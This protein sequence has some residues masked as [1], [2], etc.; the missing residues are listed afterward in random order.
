MNFGKAITLSFVLFALFIGV[1]VGVCMD[2]DISLVSPDYYQREIQH[3]DKMAVLGQTLQLRSRP[4]FWFEND[5]I[6]VVWSRLPE[7][8]N[9]RLRFYRPS[10]QRLDRE[11]LLAHMQTDTLTT[12]VTGLQPGLYRASL[13]WAM[14][15]C[16]Y[17]IEQVIIR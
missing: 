13:S 2:Q 17:L 8:E 9:P 16:D 11:I 12:T 6:A 4:V 7:M 3:G 15:G 10:D 1:L 5:R 14:H